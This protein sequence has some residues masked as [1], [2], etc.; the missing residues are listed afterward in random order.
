MKA[1]RTFTKQEKLHILRE[2]AEKGVKST[3][4]KHGI[5]PAT[6]YGWRNKFNAMGVEGLSHG[7]T[8]AHLKRISKLEKENQKL[9]QIVAEKELENR[10]QADLLKKK[11][12]LEKKKQTVM[13][14]ISQGLKSRIAFAVSTVSKHQYYY[15]QEFGKR[16]T[17]PTSTTPVI[18]NGQVEAHDNQKVVE[19]IKQIQQDPDLAYGYRTMSKALQGEGYQINHKKVYRLMKEH[20]LLKPKKKS[21]AKTYVKYRKVQ[22]T[23]PLE[24][25]EMDIKMVWVERDRRHAYILNILDTFTRK[26][27]YQTVGF[28]ITQYQVKQAWEYLIIHHLQEEDTLKRN[29]HIEVRNDNDKRF[30]A[31]MIQEF[32][33]QNHLNQVFTH[34]YTPQENGHI[35]SFHGILSQHLKRFTFW[36]FNELEQNLILFQEKYNNGRLHSSIAYLCPHDFEVLWYKDSIAMSI[37]K[38]SKQMKFQLKIPRFLIEKYTGNNEPEGSS[39]LD[40]EPP[41]VAIKSKKEIYGAKTSNNIRYKESPSV[42]PRNTNI[43]PKINIFEKLKR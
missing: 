37:N 42:V 19:R 32:F 21:S 18:T 20:Q 36:S 8:P 25:L 4:E 41:N 27:L 26:W 39:S 3:L 24:V 7:M 9:K 40:F 31:N 1:K 29:L 28:S 34:P 15:R 33:K 6:Y 2:A 16:G 30:S 43:N 38:T 23:R 5:Y 35:E 11:W 13:R 22:P 12:A 14:Y 17:K 10:L